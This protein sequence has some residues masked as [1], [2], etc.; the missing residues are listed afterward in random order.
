MSIDTHVL[1]RTP[2]SAEEVR[3]SLLHDPELID[4]KLVDR[5]TGSISGELVTVLVEPWTGDDHNLIEDGFEAATVRIKLFP[6]GGSPG[7]DA[8]YRVLAAILRLVPGDVCLA[9]QDAAGPDLLRLSGV[10]HVDP[11]GFRPENLI[12][13]GYHPERIV[14][15]IPIANV[16]GAQ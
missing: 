3:A 15:G 14:V 9:N 12:D 8:S 13:F 16:E 11:D 2:L 7:W 5:G 10:V 6:K 4:L 1:L